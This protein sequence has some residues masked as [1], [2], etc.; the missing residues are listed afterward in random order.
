ME[1]S[2]SKKRKI[3]IKIN[4]KDCIM[5]LDTRAIDNFQIVNEMGIQ[6]ALEKMKAGSTNVVYKLIC[7]MVREKKTGIILGR[8]YFK[9]YD[10]FDVI[11]FLQPSILNLLSKDMPEAKNESEKK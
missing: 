7:S 2:L 3:D 6:K 5:C 11:K 1:I 4:N 8:D 9:D 10:E